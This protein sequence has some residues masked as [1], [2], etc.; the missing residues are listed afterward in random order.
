MLGT[1]IGDKSDQGIDDLVSKDY[2]AFLFSIASG[3][4][5]EMGHVFITY[6]SRAEAVTPPQINARVL[7][8]QAP[9]GGR[10]GESGHSL[11]DMVFGGVVTVIQEPICGSRDNEV[12]VDVV[13]FH[14]YRS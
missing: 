11:E 7:K 1:A 14:S 4:F 6:L 13:A 5:H 8:H 12:C 3:V 2:R 9:E 10:R